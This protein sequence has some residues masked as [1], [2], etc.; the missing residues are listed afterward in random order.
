[1]RGGRRPVRSAVAADREFVGVLALAVDRA[2]ADE[3]QLTDEQRQKL[4]TL[5]ER[6]ENEVLELALSLRQAD[7]PERE[8]KLGPFRQASEAE[9]LK[10][11]DDRQR[12]LL[13]QV[14]LRRV[15]S[16]W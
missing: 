13:E 8:A 4:S 1:M 16:E 3:L 9:G 15:G 7:A 10:L 6:R 5:I 2:V 14:R 11:L 12:A